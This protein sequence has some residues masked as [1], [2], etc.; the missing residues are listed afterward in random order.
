MAARA[1]KALNTTAG[2]NNYVVAAIGKPE[3]VCLITKAF[4][5]CGLNRHEIAFIYK[6]ASKHALHSTVNVCKYTCPQGARVTLHFPSSIHSCRWISPDQIS[7]CCCAG[8]LWSTTL[9]EKT[10]PVQIQERGVSQ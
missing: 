9:G 8:S 7:G 1:I 4:E 10:Q 5:E 2:L 3:E 6:E